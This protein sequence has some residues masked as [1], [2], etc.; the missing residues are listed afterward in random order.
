MNDDVKFLDELAVK[1]PHPGVVEIA[2]GDY[3]RLLIIASDSAILRRAAEAYAALEA[4]KP[5]LAGGWK[6]VPVEPTDAMIIAADDTY[7]S[8]YT[9]TPFS[10]PEDVWKAM[11]AASPAPPVVESRPI[12]EAPRDGSIFWSLDR[13]KWRA[14]RFCSAEETAKLLDGK[15]EDFND[16]WCDPEDGS[17]NWEPKIWLSYSA[18]TA[19]PAPATMGNE[20]VVEFPEWKN[21]PS[22][23]QWVVCKLLRRY[24]LRASDQLKDAKAAYEGICA[25]LY[26]ALAALN[27]REGE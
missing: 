16:V 4:S 12:N 23:D 5:L 19:S 21:L 2:Q 20:A 3:E 24:E 7:R 18:L 1:L 15:P 27:Q 14:T 25:L 11:L 6:M 26:R 8:G 13:D 10:P 9:G 22:S 17:D